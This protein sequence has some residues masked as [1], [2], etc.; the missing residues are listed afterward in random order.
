MPVMP[1]TII[2]D[3][4]RSQKSKTLTR[5]TIIDV[6]TGKEFV[7]AEGTTNYFKP[8]WI[9]TGALEYSIDGKKHHMSV[10]EINE[11]LIRIKA[12]P[13]R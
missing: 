7:I 4:H 13:V 12:L 11:K 1:V 10:D 9:S 5:L 3:R 2:G 8:A 6:F